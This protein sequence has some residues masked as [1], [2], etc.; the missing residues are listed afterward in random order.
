MES[1]P[2]CL[3][4]GAEIEFIV[5][6]D[7]DLYKDDQLAVKG[8]PYSTDAL[9]IKYG[10]LVRKEIIKLL[11]ENGFPTNDYRCV[12]FSK[13]TVDSDDTVTSDEHSPNWYPIE[14]KTPV[15][16]CSP[17]TLKQVE[18]VM[19][20]LVCRFDLHVNNSCGLH[21]HVGNQDRGFTLRTLKNFCSLITAFERQLDSL[22]PP[23]RVQSHF[24]VPVH[25]VFNPGTPLMEKLMIIDELETV[26]DLILRFNCI[27][28][29][30]TKVRHMAFNFLNL[31]QTLGVPL[32]TIEFRQH[33]GTLD[34]KSITNW[35]VVACSLVNISHTIYRE[36]F[37]DLI[38]K[39]IDDNKYT[40]LDLFKDLKLSDLADFYATRVFSPCEADQN[41]AMMTVDKP[42]YHPGI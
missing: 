27:D 12:D 1:A 8:N 28:R 11:N 18:T 24:A 20:L 25:R 16:E 9:R 23:E 14:L 2:L 10:I 3:T 35:V 21:V 34:P 32:R 39:Y 6:Y 41:P 19:K 5:R 42:W 30:P 15:L 31:Q 38:E 13:W 36:G 29:V 40:V 33:R 26:N 22:H 37:C 7:P 4:F 17:T